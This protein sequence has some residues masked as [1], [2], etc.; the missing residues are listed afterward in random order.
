MLLAAEEIGL[1]VH[2][3]DVQLA[4][5]D[6][7]VHVLVRRVEAAGVA[8]HADKARFLLL[9]Q[10]RLAVGPAVGQRNFH[11]HVLARVHAGDGLGSVHL[12]G[13]AQDHRIDV[14]TRERILKFG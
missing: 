4:R 9:R 13:G 1:D 7:V 14:V 2:L 3:L 12:G 5:L 10:H 11:L 8:D 6:P